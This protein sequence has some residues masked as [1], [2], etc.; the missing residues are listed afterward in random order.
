MYAIWI[1][2]GLVI[3]VLAFS[4]VVGLV[5]LERKAARQLE[6][7]LHRHLTEASG[8]SVFVPGRGWVPA[9][10]RFTGGNE[11]LS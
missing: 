7:R 6:Q 4:L 8:M 9:D 5:A 11:C 1:L 10:A 2:A 3:F